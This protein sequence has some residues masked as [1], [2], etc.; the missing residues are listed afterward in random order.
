MTRNRVIPIWAKIGPGGVKEII[1]HVW[2]Q[3]QR[4][5]LAMSAIVGFILKLQ[6][7]SSHISREEPVVSYVYA[8]HRQ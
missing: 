1:M 3:K 7:I 6:A 4:V 2:G 8:D 5:L